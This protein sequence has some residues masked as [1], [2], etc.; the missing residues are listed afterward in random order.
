MRRWSND[1]ALLKFDSGSVCKE[2]SQTRDYCGA[3]NAPRRAARPDPS[4]R[5]KRLLRMTIKLNHN[6]KF[7]RNWLMSSHSYDSCR[8]VAFTLP[9]VVAMLC[10]LGT[11]AAA[12]D[13]P[14]PKW[15]L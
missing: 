6:V 1:V 4:L 2:A 15:E 7:R 9:A 3:K 5:K 12:Q 13:Q 8:R 10:G 11:F 14:A